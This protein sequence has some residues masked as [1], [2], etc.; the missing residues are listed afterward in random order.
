MICSFK[1][2]WSQ[3]CAAMSASPSKTIACAD[4][5]QLSA[6]HA[7]RRV[8]LLTEDK[9]VVLAQ[10]AESAKFAEPKFAQ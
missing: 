2:I 7:E 4:G 9:V 10:A 8:T 5:P 1:P 3:P 6:A